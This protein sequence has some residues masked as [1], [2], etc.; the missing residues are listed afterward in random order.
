MKRLL[1][2]YMSSCRITSLIDQTWLSSQ[3]LLK[4]KQNIE[5][6]ENKM[7]KK[8]KHHNKRKKRFKSFKNTKRTI[9]IKYK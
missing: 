9:I 7:Q 2:F 1:H 8:N 3:L 5:D 4:T 6:R